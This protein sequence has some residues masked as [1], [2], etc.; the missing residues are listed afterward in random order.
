[1]V[2]F[3]KK[4]GIEL[5]LQ[6]HEYRY[7]IPFPLFVAAAA[8]TTTTTQQQ[9]QQQ[10]QHNS[11]RS[12]FPPRLISHKTTLRRGGRRLLRHELDGWISSP[13]PHSA[14]SDAG[15]CRKM[16]NNIVEC[17]G[18]TVPWKTMRGRPTYFVIGKSGV[19][20][21]AIGHRWPF[22]YVDLLYTSIHFGHIVMLFTATYCHRPAI[23]LTL[24]LRNLIR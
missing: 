8:T 24:M 14:Y 6:Y 23:R 1:M 4:E 19:P 3:A 2:A 5:K 9:Q 18:D 11:N 15:C 10:Q 13:Y 17:F 21:Q 22:R 16:E 12:S 20:G 7:G